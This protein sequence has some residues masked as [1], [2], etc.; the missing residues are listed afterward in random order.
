MYDA[1]I[2]SLVI[3][4]DAKAIEFYK[5]VFGATELAVGLTSG[6]C[7]TCAGLPPNIANCRAIKAT[8]SLMMRSN[9]LLLPVFFMATTLD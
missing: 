5:D 1:L 3:R 8:C 9:K 2:P 7:T 6:N 4:D